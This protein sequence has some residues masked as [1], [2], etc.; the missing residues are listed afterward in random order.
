MDFRSD[1]YNK[2]L[3][4]GNNTGEANGFNKENGSR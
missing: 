1:I 2:T 3:P 4:S